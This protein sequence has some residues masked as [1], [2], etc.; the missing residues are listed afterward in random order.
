MKPAV[1]CGVS[2]VQHVTLQ[3]ADAFSRPTSFLGKF[4]TALV[5]KKKKNRS[6]I[7]ICVHESCNWCSTYPCPEQL[8]FT[9]TPQGAEHNLAAERN[10]AHLLLEGPKP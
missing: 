10:T 2:G 1:W 7:A 8:L 4:I 6:L 5:V 9:L 3:H